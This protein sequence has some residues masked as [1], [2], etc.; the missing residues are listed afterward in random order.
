M[1]QRLEHS[2][3]SSLQ[4][5]GKLLF[6]IVSEQSVSYSLSMAVGQKPAQ[7]YGTAHLAASGKMMLAATASFVG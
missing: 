6:R 7:P 2:F 4:E 3:L 1:A 5:K